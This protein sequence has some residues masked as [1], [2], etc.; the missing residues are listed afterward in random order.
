MNMTKTRNELENEL[1]HRL[2]QFVWK[3]SLITVLLFL[4][5]LYKSAAA[6]ITALSASLGVTNSNG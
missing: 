6:V 2:S 5:V 1:V 3:A 4:Y